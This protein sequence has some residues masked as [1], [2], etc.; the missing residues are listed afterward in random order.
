M[1][2][3]RPTQPC[4]GTW[5]GFLWE[6]RT[7]RTAA[8]IAAYDEVVA[9]FGDSDAPNLQRWVALALVEKGMRQAGIGRAKDALCVCE[10]IAGRIGALSEN[11]K[12]WFEWQA[13]CVRAL[14]L[15]AQQKHPAAM[16]AF[17]SAYAAFLPNNEIAMHG[18]LRLVPNLIAAGGVGI[19]PNEDSVLRLTSA[20]LAEMVLV[21]TANGNWR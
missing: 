13:M 18:M 19:F 11:L 3:P 8:A 20:I 1:Q 14:A 9:R 10:D 6:L 5:M 15:K 7:P 21:Q 4:I 16:D 12:P 17:R 2:F